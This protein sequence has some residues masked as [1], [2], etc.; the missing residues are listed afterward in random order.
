MF[1]GCECDALRSRS[2]DSFPFLFLARRRRRRRRPHLEM[3]E[4]DL[5][6]AI[7]SEIKP[8]MPSLVPPARVRNELGAE[9]GTVMLKRNSS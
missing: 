7:Y 8:A 3:A 9:I 5:L 6:E 2:L 4:N 1:S